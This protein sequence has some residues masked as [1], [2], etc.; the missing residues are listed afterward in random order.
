MGGRTGDWVAKRLMED[1]RWQLVACIVAMTAIASPQYAW[2]LFTGPLTRGLNVQLSDV[3]AAFTLF[4]LAQ[5][6]LVPVL[7]Y[8]MDRIGARVVVAV[9][10]L[11]VGVSWVGCGLAGSLWSLYLFY[12]I[13]GVGVAGVYGACM[14]LALKWFPDRRGLA[15]GLV[16]GAY[17]SGAAL[18]VVPIRRLILGAGYRTAFIAGGLLLG[19]VLLI[20][21]WP[22]MTPYPGWRPPEGSRRLGGE[23]Q[24]VQQA[25]RSTRPGQMIRS[26][27]FHLLYFVAILVTFGGLMISAQLKPIAVAHGIEMVSILPGVDVLSFTLM[28]NLIVAALARPFWGW[29]SDRIGR[30]ST[31]AIAFTLGGVAILG[32][33]EFVRAPWG[34]AFFSCLTAFTW[35]ASFV[36]FSAAIGDTFGS[37]YAATNN[38]IHYTSKGV[39]AIFAG[40]GAAR[41]V[42]ATGSW[43]PVFW[44]GVVC[45]LVAAAVVLF[46]LRPM[47]ARVVGQSPGGTP[48]RSAG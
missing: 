2:T 36:L 26:G 27:T 13:G 30:Y 3:Q 15:T 32:L 45:N 25:T 42:E 1:R 47:I 28:A 21:A 17:G 24:H 22:M 6:W 7:G 8:V 16:V 31:M 46:A 48:A 40:W 29:L 38:G 44:L 4:V 20:V 14:G 9:G 41:L 18:T 35:G 5:S 23:P 11:L 33:L 37:A 34:F 12:T 39:A 10:G 19:V 43:A